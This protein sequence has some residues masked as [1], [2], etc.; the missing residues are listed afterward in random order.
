M[1]A[2]SNAEVRFSFG[3]RPAAISIFSI[4]VGSSS[5]AR[6]LFTRFDTGH[7]C[8]RSFG[9][10]FNNSMPAV[11]LSHGS[12]SFSVSNAG[13]RSCSSATK[14]LGAQITIV[15]DFSGMPV[16]GFFHSSHKPT[17]VSAGEPSRAV[18]YKGCLPPGVSCHS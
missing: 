13:I 2:R 12:K 11:P 15:Q 16:S 14:S 5:L 17:T 10:G 9:A 3:S 6:E 18:K 1:V 7:F 4:R 8:S